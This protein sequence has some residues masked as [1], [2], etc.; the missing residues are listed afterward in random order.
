MTISTILILV[1]LALLYI[2]AFIPKPYKDKGEYGEYLIEND[3]KKIKW[4][5]GRNL[6]NLYVPKTSDEASEIDVVYICTKG[7]FVIESKNYSGWIFGNKYDSYWTATLSNKTKN[8]FYNPIKQNAN[9][10][11]YLQMYIERYFPDKAVPL[12]P[13]VVFS[14]RCELK[15]IKTT[16]QEPV[17]QRD[18]L[19]RTISRTLMDKDEI[20]TKNEVD[21]LYEELYILTCADEEFKQSHVKNIDEKYK[22]GS[23]KIVNKTLGTELTN[24]PRCGKRVIIK[25]ELDENKKERKVYVCI[26][27]PECQYSRIID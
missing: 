21:K 5:Y 2:S 12:Y 11:K 16:D 24:C 22:S 8:K 4:I 14:T 20:L 18:M 25:N 13:L 10:M 15:N 17:I 23:K 3:L 27:Y 1:G 26:A 6:R 19:I 9:H 7:V